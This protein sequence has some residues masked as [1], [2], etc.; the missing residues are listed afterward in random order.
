MAMD[1][2][3]HLLVNA[4]Q[5]NFPSPRAPLPARAHRPCKVPRVDNLPAHTVKAWTA[6]R[7]RTLPT[8]GTDALHVDNIAAHTTRA[9]TVGKPIPMFPTLRLP[10]H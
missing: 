2:F 7:V 9:W 10:H 8:L 3:E 1:T 4:F 6:L 5:H